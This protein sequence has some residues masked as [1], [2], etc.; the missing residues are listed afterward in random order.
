VIGARVTLAL[1]P[2]VLG[3]LAAGRRT[4]IVSGTNGKSTTTAMLAA[5]GTAGGRRVVSNVEGA[6]LR[7]GIV[8]SLSAAADADLAVLEIDELALP[9]LLPSFADPVVVLL[10]LSRD[11]LDRFG[12]VRTV[13]AGW[14]RAFSDRDDVTVIANA[15]DPLVVWGA[16]AAAHQVYVGVGL[17]WRLD[18]AACPAC[19]GR[20]VVGHRS[21]HCD[22][23]DLQRP[24]CFELDD[25]ALLDGDRIVVEL[26]P[27]VPGRHNVANAA[28]AVLAAV[29]LGI[30]VAVAAAAIT[31]VTSVAGRYRTVDV[32]GTAARLLLA[33]NPAGWAEL[34]A[35]ID[36]GSKPLLLAINARI[37][38]GTDPSWLW[39]VPYEQLVGRSVI[40]AGDRAADLAVR[41]HYADVPC[42]LWR[43]SLLDR[44][45][46][47]DAP[48]VDVLANYTAFADLVRDLG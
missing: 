43:G 47:H 48:A 37:A 22:T 1:A 33:K 12:E 36:G 40:A 38:D 20:I 31:T 44:L 11:Q 45:R 34:L 16:S 26:T 30:D 39:D 42:E 2:N 28:Q 32:D 41:L 4:A 8:A 13:A 6:N 35:L 29:E 7:T 17:P 25:T 24:A 19:G 46:A 23:C 14:R 18:A 5:A 9:Q 21:W 3:E 27:G 10:N 15:D